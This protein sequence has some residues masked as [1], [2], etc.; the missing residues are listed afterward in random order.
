MQHDYTNVVSCDEGRLVIEC[1]GCGFHHFHP[2][3]DQS[4]LEHFYAI[5]YT[6]E[7]SKLQLRERA[8][9]IHDTCKPKRVLDVG[10]GNGDFMRELRKLGIDV[11][12]IEP[13]ETCRQACH[14]DGLDVEYE[15]SGKN[16][17][18]MRF[19]VVNM[20][21]LLEHVANP[22]EFMA[23]IK[24]DF[25]ASDGYVSI[26]VPNDF[27]LLQA[28]YV[29]HGKGKEYWIKFPDHLNYWNFPSFTMFLERLGF[30]IVF[31]TSS[32]P[33][34]FFLLMDEDYIKEKERGKLIH[35]KRLLFEQKFK[36][37]GH[38]RTLF[39]LYAKLLEMN[40]GRTIDVIA[41]VKECLP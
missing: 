37:T 41:R 40:V 10:C 6:D 18:G 5:E 3:P 20:S 24:R 39:E 8:R 11:R 19:D 4:F 22:Y 7:L 32:F 25:L 34:E 38:T 29:A 13:S 21:F 31:K 9:R 36:E 28:I 12:G 17:F 27:N 23:N 2:Y 15:P 14:D 33:V 26:E 1:I 16:P 30:S 35:Q